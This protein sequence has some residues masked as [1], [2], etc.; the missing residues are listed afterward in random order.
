PIYVVFSVPSVHLNAIYANTQRGPL[1]VDILLNGR[2]IDQGQLTF[3]DNNVDITTGSIQLKATVPNKQRQ[4]WPGQYVTVD[5]PVKFIKNAILIP[6][7]ALLTGQKGFYVYVMDDD[8]TVH[9]RELTPGPSIGNDVVI[10]KGLKPGEKVITAG[11][12]QLKEGAKV[13]L[14]SSIVE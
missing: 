6:S 14:A 7:L 4:L 12:S 10:E 13:K 1:N 8:E 9:M 5:L 11:Q 2:K 3:I